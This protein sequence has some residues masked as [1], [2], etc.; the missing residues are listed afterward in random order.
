MTMILTEI[1]GINDIII[2]I[3][4][5]GD[6]DLFTTKLNCRLKKFNLKLILTCNIYNRGMGT[7]LNLIMIVF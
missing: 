2:V 7:T 3:G 6:I 1:K 4:G 5:G